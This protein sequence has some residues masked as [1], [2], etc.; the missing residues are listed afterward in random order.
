MKA[1]GILLLTSLVCC[2]SYHHMQHPIRIRCRR[3]TTTLQQSTQE[4]LRETM[5]LKN[6]SSIFLLNA[7]RFGL[8]L[9]LADGLKSLGDYEEAEKFAMEVRTW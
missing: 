3:V 6:V 8:D 1:V 4:L 7:T 5:E 9:A 2:S